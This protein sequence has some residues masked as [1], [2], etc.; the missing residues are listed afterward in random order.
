MQAEHIDTW[1][2]CNESF[3]FT[4]SFSQVIQHQN[5]PYQGARLHRKITRYYSIYMP[6]LFSLRYQ[7]EKLQFPR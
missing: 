1:H 3:V 2:W 4:F 5:T 7:C 6:L